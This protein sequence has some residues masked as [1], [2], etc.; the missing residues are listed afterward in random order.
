MTPQLHYCHVTRV[1]IKVKGHQHRWFAGGYD[2]EFAG[3]R[4]FLEV[5]SMVVSWWRV[6]FLP[7]DINI[8][9]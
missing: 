9:S 1:I 7:S 4:T 3:N 5:D 8:T 6:A 2:L